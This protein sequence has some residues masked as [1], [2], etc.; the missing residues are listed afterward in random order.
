[1]FKTELENV[2]YGFGVNIAQN[3]K[4]QGMKEMDAGLLSVL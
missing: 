1:M 3:M 2:S 4:Q